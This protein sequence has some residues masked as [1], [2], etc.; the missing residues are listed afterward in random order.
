MMTRVRAAG[1]TLVLA[2]GLLGA[3]CGGQ[4]ALSRQEYSA[5][6]NAICMQVSEDQR[7]VGQPSSLNEL[8]TKGPRLVE[9]LDRALDEVRD[10]RPPKTLRVAHNRFVALAEELNTNLLDLVEAAKANDQTKASQVSS[11]IDLLDSQSEAIAR[12]QLGAPSCAQS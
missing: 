12:T 10:L 6:L 7:A 3:G 1:V 4:A 8:A 9:I 5:E 2:A 11:A